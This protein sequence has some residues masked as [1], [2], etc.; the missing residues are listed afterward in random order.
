MKTIKSIG[1]ILI[2]ILLAF[3]ILYLVSIL[4]FYFSKPDIDLLDPQD[5]YW[6]PQIENS[7]IELEYAFSINWDSEIIID[8]I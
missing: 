8:E 1:K 6:K 2:S 5:K 4:T 3:G 7:R